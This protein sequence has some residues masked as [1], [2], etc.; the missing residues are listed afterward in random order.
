MIVRPAHIE[1][2]GQVLEL[3]RELAGEALEARQK[4]IAVERDL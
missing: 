2:M 4:I 1:D 3:I